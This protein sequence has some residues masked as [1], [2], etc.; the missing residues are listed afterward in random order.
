MPGYKGHLVGGFCAFVIMAYLC[1]TSQT[2]VPV[3]FGWMLCTLAGSLFP[4]VDISSK[5]Q[6]LLFRLLFVVFIGLLWLQ[7]THTALCVSLCSFVPLLVRHRGLF[8][9]LWFIALLASIPLL[10]AR[11]QSQHVYAMLWYPIIFF[12]VG[13]YSHV[14]LDVGFKRMWRL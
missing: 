2:T 9:R 13:A 1:K 10:W 14:Y 4:D 3:L 6:K 12:V 5:G 11:A 7:Q 8:H